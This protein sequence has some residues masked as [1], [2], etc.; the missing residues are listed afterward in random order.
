LQIFVQRDDRGERQRR[1][2]GLR[3]AERLKVQPG[4]QLPE[5]RR[6]PADGLW[7]QAAFAMLRST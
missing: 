2:C 3:Q 7:R 6:R 5:A 1:A 4:R